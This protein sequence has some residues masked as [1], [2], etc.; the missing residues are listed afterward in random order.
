MHAQFSDLLKRYPRLASWLMEMLQSRRELRAEALLPSFLLECAQQG[1]TGDTYPFTCKDHGLTDLRF[2]L[3]NAI[4]DVEATQVTHVPPFLS[5]APSVPA[6]QIEN[7]E[8]RAMPA[9]LN[10]DGEPGEIDDT[11]V[12]RQVSGE[13]REIDDTPA[14]RDPARPSHRERTPHVQPVAGVTEHIP[15]LQMPPLLAEA[16]THENNPGIVEADRNCQASTMFMGEEQAT[17]GA[18]GDTHAADE[19][20]EKDVL[21]NEVRKAWISAQETPRPLLR[22]RLT[23]LR[24]PRIQ[25]RDHLARLRHPRTRREGVISLVLLVVILGAI[26]APAAFLVSFGIS[27]YTTYHDVSNRAHSAVDHLLTVKTL[28][29]GGKSHLTAVFDVATLQQAQREFVAS[30]QD[31]QQVQDQLQHSSTLHTIVTY[32]PQ[33]RE[34]LRSAQTASVMGRDVARI[35]QLVTARAIQF[36]PAFS[37]S[38]L[39]VSHKPL[40]TQPMLMAIGTTLDQVLPL[41]NDIQARSQTLS[42]NALPISAHEKDQ[43][44]PLLQVLPQAISGLTQVRQLLGTVGW[45]LGVDHPRTFLVQTMD[46]AELRATG[47]FTGQYGDLTINGGRVEPFNLRDIS[48]VEYTNNS[49]TYGQ[50]APTQYRSWWPFANWGMR[51]SNVSADFPTSAQMALQLYQ[52][53]VGTQADGVMSFTPVVIEHILDIIGPINVPGYNVTA[54]S[55][56]LE[57]LLHYYQLNNNGILKQIYQQPGNQDT[58]TRKRFTNTLASLLMGKVRSAPPNEL[59]AMARQVLADL[60][61]KDL[62]IYFTDPSA[63]GLLM[64]YGYAGQMDRSTMHDGL[65]VVQE[66]LSASKASQYVQTMMHDIVTLNS[67]GGAT[68]VLQIRLVYNQDGPVYGYDTYFDYLRVYVPPSSQLLWGD[69]F[70]GSRPL[71]GGSYGGC[72]VN[73]P[74]PNG[75]LACP[76]G[77]YQPGA[78]PPTL[79]G[80]DGA[81]RE[82]LRALSGPTNTASDEP[83]RAM[84]GGWVIVPKNCTMNVTLSWYVPP[85]SQQ[86]YSLLVQRQAGTFPQLDLTILPGAASCTY[87]GSADLRFDNTLVEDVSFAPVPLRAQRR[88]CDAGQG[89]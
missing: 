30:D 65:Y 18:V 1:I 14:A 20:V 85:M 78:E 86:P 76:A 59:F 7:G 17:S 16:V 6:P 69:G 68:H 53:E 73:G 39:S 25:L 27:A 43:L 49:N 29:S 3:H 34:P 82:P 55:Q 4:K 52:Q 41:L 87:L 79:T 74:Y 33:Y 42:L 21:A 26:L 36:A 54:T 47:G 83:G 2:F 56:N 84:Y 23:Y 89:T 58:S 63:E 24:H 62:Q 40:L 8:C 77:Q 67:Q 64:R 61:T 19:G 50:L 22:G 60:K 5:G 13:M 9:A 45:L 35:G 71:C 72:P 80:S 11:P 15:L 57:D 81:T 70:E 66:N 31:F 88:G 28:F 46:R 32:L 44:G 12:V 75:E 51:D 48:L 38:L 10:A 37:G